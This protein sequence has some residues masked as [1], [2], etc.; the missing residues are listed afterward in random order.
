MLRY[1]EED[2]SHKFAEIEDVAAFSSEHLADVLLHTARGDAGATAAL[3]L[4]AAHDCWLRRSDFRDES[5]RYW[6]QENELPEA[7]EVHWDTD[8]D[9]FPCSSSEHGILSI[10]LSL[11]G[12]ARSVNLRDTLSGLDDRNQQLVLNAVAAAMDR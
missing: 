2:E 8:P 7:A 5:I 10:A 9:V 11:G 12:R 6:P 3:H 1:G 4:L